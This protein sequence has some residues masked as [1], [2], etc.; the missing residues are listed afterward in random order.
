MIYAI[1]LMN[2][3]IEQ[4]HIPPRILLSV[5]APNKI[6]MNS[7]LFPM[8]MT[9]TKWINEAI[10]EKLDRCGA[11]AAEQATLQILHKPEDE[12]KRLL[13]LA[14]GRNYVGA[15][16]LKYKGTTI[17]DH[18]EHV[19][20]KMG[21]ISPGIEVI[22]EDLCEQSNAVLST[23]EQG[24]ILAAHTRKLKMQADDAER[25]RLRE[26]REKADMLAEANA[27]LVNP[28]IALRAK[29][30]ASQLAKHGKAAMDAESDNPMEE[31]PLIN[32]ASPA[33]DDDADFWGDEDAAYHKI[34]AKASRR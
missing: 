15:Y 9:L 3:P 4:N 28:Q 6:R 5:Y 13:R 7:L 11:V 14:R 34:K 31:Q 29:F 25:K 1:D 21:D 32:V 16:S 17:Y 18:A 2:T 26:E 20:K 23:E 30:E 24:A 22:L 19:D 8:G 12:R 27:P 33:M 10:T